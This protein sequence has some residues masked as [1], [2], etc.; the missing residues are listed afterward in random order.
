[1]CLSVLP[2]ETPPIAG[3]NAAGLA[4]LTI[5]VNRDGSGNVTSATIN[6]LVS[7]TFTGSVTVTGLHIHEGVA[8]TTGSVVFNTGLSSGNSLTFASGSGLINL[9]ATSV[10]ITD[11]NDCWAN[12]A[13]FYVNLHTSANPNGSDSRSTYQTGRGAGQYHHPQLRQ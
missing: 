12:P 13:G 5:T 6:F 4:A 1:M 2:N 7:A 10:D 8:T 9:N 11:S 3:L